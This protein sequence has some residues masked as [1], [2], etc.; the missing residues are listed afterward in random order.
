M[1]NVF[2]SPLNL[3]C[4]IKFLT[5]FIVS[6]NQTVQKK[7]I[8]FCATGKTVNNKINLKIW[9]HPKWKIFA[10]T[11]IYVGF[12]PAVY[13]LIFH[14]INGIDSLNQYLYFYILY[15]WKLDDI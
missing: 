5:D 11:K 9:S 2:K 13:I 7:G 6:S 3:K 8:L 14:F 1:P 15:F 10:K 4:Y 12:D